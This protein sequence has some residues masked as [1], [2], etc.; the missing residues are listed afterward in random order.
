MTTMMTMILQGNEG[1][2][3][4]N[5]GMKTSDETRTKM[6]MRRMLPLPLGN[7]LVSRSHWMKWWVASSGERLSCGHRSWRECPDHNGR[8]GRSRGKVA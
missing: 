8:Q 1:V 3:R 6:M 4:G 2:D 7:F 5:G